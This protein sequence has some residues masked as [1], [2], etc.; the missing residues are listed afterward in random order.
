MLV[1][2]EENYHNDGL[3]HFS[4]VI[5]IF[6]PSFT[7]VNKILVDSGQNI[8]LRIFNPTCTLKTIFNKNQGVFGIRFNTL[9]ISIGCY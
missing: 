8:S 1:K 2:M 3:F 6:L 7:K 4:F 5:E 9:I